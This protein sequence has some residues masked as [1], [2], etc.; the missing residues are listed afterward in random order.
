ME[1][2]ALLL[3]DPGVGC[4]AGVESHGF[5]RV[6]GLAVPDDVRDVFIRGIVVEL[7]L[8]L[9]EL[10]VAAVPAMLVAEAVVVDDRRRDLRTGGAGL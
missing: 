8:V 5:V 10:V 2:P 4:S 1:I 3:E 9:D 6:P 7:L